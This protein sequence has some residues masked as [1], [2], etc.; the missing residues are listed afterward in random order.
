MDPQFVSNLVHE[1]RDLELYE[2]LKVGDV[3][4]ANNNAGNWE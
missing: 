2:G 4:K 3:K 1:K